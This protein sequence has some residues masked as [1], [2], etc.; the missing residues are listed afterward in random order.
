MKHAAF[1]ATLTA[2]ALTALALT[3]GCRSGAPK[4]ILTSGQ[5]L[6]SQF[7]EELIIRHFFDDRRGGTFVD[8]GA[9]HWRDSST[10]LYLEKHLGWT[11]IAVDAQENVRQ[12]Y[13][14]NRP[15]TR[16]FNY[17]VGDA[18]G[19]KVKFFVAGP[20]SS[21]QAGYTKQ[22]EET[23]NDVPQEIEVETITMNDL[24]ARERVRRIDFLSMDI[25]ESEPAALAGFDIAKYRPQ[26]VCIEAHDAVQDAL[27]T[28]F[29]GHGYERIEEYLDYD[30]VNWYFRPKRK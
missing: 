25:E 28:Y 5:K 7:D 10:T 3:A 11:G 18:S 1:A 13:V 22:F 23:K 14:D 19:R 2:L 4:D 9:W 29:A 26:L 12:G 17:A 16:F 30:K 6:Y 15:G 27:T 20:L 8:I 24:L 21:T